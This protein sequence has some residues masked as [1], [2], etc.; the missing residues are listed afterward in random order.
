MLDA[1]EED[2]KSLLKSRPLIC[3]EIG[4]APSP[5]QT[6][7]IDSSGSGIVSTFLAS[8]LDLLPLLQIA[9]DINRDAC[10]VTQNTV[11]QNNVRYLDIVQTDLLSGI[12]ER[13][14][15]KVDVLVFNPPYVPTDD[16]E[17]QTSQQQLLS[18]DSSIAIAASWAGGSTGMNVTNRLLQVVPRILSPTGVFYLVC[19]QQN[20]TDKIRSDMLANGLQSTVVLKRLAGRERLSVVKF[21][22]Q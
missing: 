7:L 8:L 12:L 10:R 18:G 11:R 16:D 9:V 3:L 13:L 2:Q 19:I 6:M 20:N 17:E 15:N 1:L 14:H 21:Y 22:R 4:W 5:L